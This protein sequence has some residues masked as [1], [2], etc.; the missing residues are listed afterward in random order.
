MSG[1]NV[2]IILGTSPFIAQVSQS[3]ICATLSRMTQKGK[4]YGFCSV[5]LFVCDEESVRVI[6]EVPVA[7]IIAGVYGENLLV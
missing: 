2:G 3:F 4:R 5:S 7:E 1:E 6:E